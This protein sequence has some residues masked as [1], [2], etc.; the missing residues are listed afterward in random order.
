M[1]EYGLFSILNVR[2]KA[3]PDKLS[4][5]KNVNLDMN[6][7][8]DTVTIRFINN[9]I[10]V[11]ELLNAVTKQFNNIVDITLQPTGLE[12]VLKKYIQKAKL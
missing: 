11:E 3:P 1:T 7:V 5:I 10:K 2:L 12:E 4:I 6:I 9:Y 8:G